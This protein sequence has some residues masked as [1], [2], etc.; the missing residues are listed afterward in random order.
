[1]IIRPRPRA[2]LPG[3]FGL[4]FTLRGSII[5]LIAARI[6]LVVGVSIVVTILHHLRPRAIPELPASSFGLLGLA[7]SIFLGFRNSACYDRW[8]EAHKQWGQLL[9]EARS[10]S[11]RLQIL[12]P[13]I[14]HDQATRRIL[15]FAHALVARLRGA[16]S[17]AAA[18]AQLT[19]NEAALLLGRTNVPDAI[20]RLMT[21]DFAASLRHGDI[22]EVG[23]TALEAHVTA[24]C[25]IQ[26]ACDRIRTTP[27]PFA[28]QVAENRLPKPASRRFNSCCTLS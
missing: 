15:A 4:L 13:A 14:P 23:F 8:W 26:A 2:G 24:L 10:L 6:A 22:G 20:L 25:G 9:T 27:T 7:L 11:R 18:A 12:S 3:S 19:P 21:A 28:Y 5:P 1:M 17:A 16:D